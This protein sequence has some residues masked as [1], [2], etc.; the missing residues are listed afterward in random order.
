MTAGGPEGRAPLRK[1]AARGNMSAGAIGELGMSA[2]DEVDHLEKRLLDRMLFF[3]DAVFA[4]VLTL[5]V[6]D[7]KPPEGPGAV[8]GMN[9]LGGMA[10]H[11]VAFGMSFALVSIFWL[12]HMSTTS[13][14]RRF[15]WPSTLANLA[16][17]A[18]IC[19]IPFV[20]AWY[21]QNIGDPSSWL[22]YCWILVAT[23]TA[24]VALVLVVSRGGGRLIGGITARE[25]W[26]RALRAATPGLSFAI[27]IVLLLNG[28]GHFAQFCWVLIPPALWLEGRFFPRL[29]SPVR[30][31]PFRAPGET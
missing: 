22:I 29:T 9:A 23:S 19:L 3:T 25:T 14:L 4:I 24:N 7:L 31:G 28:L 26:H 5:L 17:L 27:G 1:P 20:S 8:Q 16:F 18:P 15:D 13:V 11:F 30:R 6:L 12:A 2:E 10:G 21:G